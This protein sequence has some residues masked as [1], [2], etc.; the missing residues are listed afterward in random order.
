MPDKPALPAV[1][2]FY[3]GPV[4]SVATLEPR[5]V[6]EPLER[7]LGVRKMER[8]VEELERLR[9]LDEARRRS[10]AERLRRQFD[11][12]PPVPVPPATPEARPP[13]PG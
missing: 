12:T 8:D 7:E 4:A 9:K 1:Q 5:I 6:T 2:V 3:R 10:E 13:T 11:P